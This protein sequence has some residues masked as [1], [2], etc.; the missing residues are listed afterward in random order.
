MQ[1]VSRSAKRFI[2]ERFGDHA[3]WHF[4]LSVEFE[5][6]RSDRRKSWPFGL[7]PDEE[8]P[9]YAPGIGYVGYVH[10]DGAVEGLY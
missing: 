3:R 8:D 1:S 9:D 5:G 4:D 10:R 7:A 2:A 6:D